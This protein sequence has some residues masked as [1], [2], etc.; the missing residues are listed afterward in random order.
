M[1]SLANFFDSLNETLGVKT[2]TELLFSP[3][4]IGLAVVIFI[5]ALY[6]GWKVFYLAIGALMGFALIYRHLYPQSSSDL[7]ALV[8]FLGACALW[9]LVL[10]YLGFVKD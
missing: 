7:S 2:P 10:I 6:M 3:Y 9:A 4:F 1:Q 8:Y 5:Y